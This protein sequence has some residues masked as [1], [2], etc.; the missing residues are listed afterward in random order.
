MKRKRISFFEAVEILLGTASAVMLA[1]F[2]VLVIGGSA[3]ESAVENEL[4][5]AMENV[6]E[7]CDS[8]DSRVD[9]K[10]NIRPYVDIYKQNIENAE[11][12]RRKAYYAGILLTYVSNRV[13]M[14]DPKMLL[15]LNK[16]LGTH[17][18]TNSMEIAS[19]EAYI[20]DIEA[21]AQRFEDAQEAFDN[22]DNQ[23]DGETT[24]ANYE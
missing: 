1:I 13:N 9:I 14:N 4:K 12:I 16:E 10:E 18:E 22:R 20:A 23:H 17:Y 21:A 15:E 6:V 3:S 2:F 8:F 7:V 19:Y 5:A 24:T 11:S